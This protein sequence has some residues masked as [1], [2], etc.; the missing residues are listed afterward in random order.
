MGIEIL[1]IQ[2]DH[3]TSFHRAVDTVAKERKYLLSLEAPP[4]QATREFVQENIDEGHSQ[5]VAIYDAEVIGWCDIL[6]RSEMV[7]QHIGVVGM[8][9]LPEFRSNGLGRRLLI[10]TLKHTASKSFRKIEL[11]VRSSNA[12]AVK[13]Y[14]TTGFVHEGVLRD[15]ILVD[16]QFDDTVCMAYFPGLPTQTRG[17]DQ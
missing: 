5:L 15:N 10:K 4:L 6:P 11:Q 17:K 3:A 13:L 16:G 8:G 12:P 2:I 14:E 1:P 7:R 9:V